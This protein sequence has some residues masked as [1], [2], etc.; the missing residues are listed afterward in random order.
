M[1]IIFIQENDEKIQFEL[2]SFRQQWHEE[3]QTKQEAHSSNG[4]QGNNNDPSPG[5]ASKKD[6]RKQEQKRNESANN[7][8]SNH[9]EHEK[10]ERVIYLINLSIVNNADF[11]TKTKQFQ[12]KLRTEKSQI[13]V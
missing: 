5:T 3:I 4:K 13:L 8:E 7:A 11:L 12:K 6:E 9:S 10:E 1:C 2:A